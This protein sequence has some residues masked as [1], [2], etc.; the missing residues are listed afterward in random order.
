[1]PTQNPNQQERHAVA[2]P[3]PTIDDGKT[4]AAEPGELTGTKVRPA[5][6]TTDTPMKKKASGPKRKRKSRQ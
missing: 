4:T 5:A 1:V 3:N 6:A 2:S